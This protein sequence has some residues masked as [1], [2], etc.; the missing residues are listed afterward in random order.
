MPQASIG[1]AAADVFTAA[2]IHIQKT[3][4]YNL[5]QLYPRAKIIGIPHL[6]HTTIGEEDQNDNSY[7]SETPYILPDQIDRQHISQKMLLENYKN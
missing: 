7:P 2:D 4:E 1:Q 3:I 5:R 6:L